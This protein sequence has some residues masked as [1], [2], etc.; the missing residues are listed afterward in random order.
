MLRPDALPPQQYWAYWRVGLLGLAAALVI[1]GCAHTPFSASPAAERASAQL[2]AR[3][4]ER[5]DHEMTLLLE[6]F[7]AQLQLLQLA[8][9]HTVRRNEL[10]QVQKVFDQVKLRAEKGV[11]REIDRTIASAVVATAGIELL[12]ATAALKSALAGHEARYNERFEKTEMLAPVWDAYWPA[13]VA[14]MIERVSDANRDEAVSAWHRVLYAHEK[15]VLHDHTL[16]QRDAVRTSYLQQFAIGQRTLLESVGAE[17]DYTTAAIERVE[18]HIELLNAKAAV[19]ALM[20]RLRTDDLPAV[21]K[22]GAASLGLLSDPDEPSLTPKSLGIADVPARLVARENATSRR[23]QVPQKSVAKTEIGTVTVVMGEVKVI[24]VDSISRNLRA[25]DKVYAGELIQTA[26]NGVVQVQL[27][28]GQTLDLGRDTKFAL[29]NAVPDADPSA[30][31]STTTNPAMAEKQAPIAAG[32]DPAAAAAAANTGVSTGGS[33]G[34]VRSNSSSLD[35]GDALG[36]ATGDCL[37]KLDWPPGGYSSETL[38]DDRLLRAD[39]GPRTHGE[40]ADLLKTA[41][42]PL[43][44][45]PAYLSVPNGFAVVTK[46]EQIRADGTHNDWGPRMPRASELGFGQFIK[47]LFRA[48]VGR[49]RVIVFVVTDAP[50]KR[51]GQAL[52][53]A[54]LA[55]LAREGAQNLPEWMQRRPYVKGKFTATA[56]I[57]EF[58][59]PKENATAALVQPNDERAHAETH[60]E[61]SGIW[62]NLKDTALGLRVR[63]RTR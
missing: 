56:L 5:L 47:A 1:T 18:A 55:A 20:G 46:L 4:R 2:Q 29:E 22:P 7:S 45:E 15:L 60:L 17:R 58:T 24:G 9:T 33:G 34:I 8:Q 14:A 36:Q 44:Y 52:G 10:Q 57:Y 50:R 23:P 16:K 62:D 51:G 59:K 6:R 38:I 19:L 25:G 12:E 53:E 49:Y 31:L 48:P 21:A 39:S 3:Q 63:P 35:C 11:G 43:G 61:N 37:P 42:E 40:I 41:L 28:K 13:S 27:M 30:P 32:E 26:A 54:R